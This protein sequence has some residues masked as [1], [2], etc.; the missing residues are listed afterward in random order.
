MLSIS[1]EKHW[2]KFNGNLQYKLSKTV[3]ELLQYDRRQLQKICSHYHNKINNQ[4]L[5]NFP[6]KLGA[7]QGCPLLLF[8]F[9]KV[10]KV[11]TNAIRQG[12]SYPD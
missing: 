7:R 4:R 1:A 3:I 12:K 8:M 9:N 11:F 6:L 5:D 2:T 10:P